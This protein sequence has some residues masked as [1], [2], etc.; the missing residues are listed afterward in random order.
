[1]I[2]LNKLF[3]ELI[4]SKSLLFLTA[5]RRESEILLKGNSFRDKIHVGRLRLYQKK[6]HLIFILETGIGIKK[7]LHY[8]R[9]IIQNIQPTCSINFGICG[10]LDPEINRYDAFL[11]N[12]VFSPGKMT[13]SLSENLNKFISST[14]LPLKMNNLLT[15]E[16]AL[17]NRKEKLDCFTK[18]S[19]PIVDMEG[20]HFASITRELNIPLLILK[21]VSDTV[22]DDVKDVVQ[23]NQQKWQLKLES[24]LD[25]TLQDL[26]NKINN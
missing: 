11:I 21:V 1:M 25:L 24:A 23:K 2:K 20:Y 4:D 8:L 3:S 14:A 18:Y 6:N 5:M 17:L 7:S 10:A 12:R 15:A 13:L 26:A 9:R 22:Q 19:I 16:K